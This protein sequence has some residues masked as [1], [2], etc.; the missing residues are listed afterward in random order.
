MIPKEL[1]V[2]KEGEITK[3]I[4][5]WTKTSN[6]LSAGETVEV[7]VTIVVKKTPC[8]KTRI[9]GSGI[10]TPTPH[11]PRNPDITAADWDTILSLDWNAGQKDILM[12]FKNVCGGTLTG[13]RLDVTSSRIGMINQ[14]F[15]RGGYPYRIRSFEH[16]YWYDR[17]LQMLK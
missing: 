14:K 12:R 8:V 13:R 7:T 17:P 15:S 4:E 10:G 16:G 11:R 5:D 3:L 1:I 2:E 9:T 6:L